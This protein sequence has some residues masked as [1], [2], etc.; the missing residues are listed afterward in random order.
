M[1]KILLIR[2]SSIGDIVLTTPVIRCL[3]EQLPGA[4][5]HYLTKRQ[6]ETL[7]R[8]NPYIH[9]IWSFNHTFRELL[10]GLKKERFDFIADLHKNLRSFRVRLCL[11]R[12][13]GSFPK[14]NLKKYL[15]TRFHIDLLP[16]VHIVDRYFQAVS[17]LAVR[18]DGRGLDYFIPGG[19]EADL[20][21]LPGIHRNGFF[22]LSIGG[23][24][25]T[26]I[27]PADRVAEVCLRLQKPIVL[28]GGPEDRARGEEIVEAAGVKVFNGC[29][30]FSINQSA[31]LIRQA[32][33]VIS[34]DTGLMHIAAAFKKPIVSI[35]GNTV[36]AFGMYPYLPQDLQDLSEIIEVH[37]LSCRPCSK[38]GYDKCPK[39]HFRCMKDISEDEIIRAV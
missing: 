20:E 14:L 34:N 6:N 37:G 7:L 28:L 3:K 10:P 12:P 18:Y 17:K 27:Y 32:E 8:A 26:K 21:L 25:N 22:A 29:G 24:H 19:E 15:L 36:P 38:L 9:K 39:K 33:K 30:V 13:A 2:F 23:K 31:S 35:W 4:E 5:I 11:R 1:T 16:K